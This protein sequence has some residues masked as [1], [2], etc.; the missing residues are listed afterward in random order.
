MSQNKHNVIKFCFYFILVITTFLA[1]VYLFLIQSEEYIV[2]KSS[3]ST[4]PSRKCLKVETRSKCL[5]YVEIADNDIKA[6][7]GLSG[8]DFMKQNH[9]M[10]FVENQPTSQ[11]FWMKEMKFALDIVWLSSDKK[12]IKIDK[13]IDPNTYPQQFCEKDVQYVLEL[14]SGFST[15]NGLNT[16]QKLIF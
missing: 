15:Q 14:N 8:R 5:V 16:G 10:L 1:V 9:G 13:N 11:C 6:I 3:E 2:N 7:K 4:Q 12:I